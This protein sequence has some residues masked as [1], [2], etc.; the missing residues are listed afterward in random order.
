MACILILQRTSANPSQSINMPTGQLKI[1]NDFYTPQ[2]KTK[3][4][5]WICL[6]SD[7]ENS[8][9]HYPVLYMHDGQS[10]FDETISYDGSWHVNVI[11]NK[12]FKDKKTEGVIIV[13]VDNAGKNRMREYNPWEEMGGRGSL[14]ADF[15]VHTLKPYIDDNFR[16][17]PQREYT[18]IMGSS[19]GAYISTY[20]ALKNQD[21][22]SKIG[23]LSPVFWLYTEQLNSFF[24]KTQIK[25]SMKMYLSV[26]TKEGEE[27]RAA[28]YLKETK[29]VYDILRDKIS[30]KIND[31]NDIKLDVIENGTHSAAEWS[32]TF[33]SALSWLF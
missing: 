32:K 18:G 5:V 20:I 22:F 33:E 16:T 29:A 31:G 9:K 7:Y 2:L 28:Q 14:Y 23:L 17:K 1:I 24:E 25:M 30:D 8:Q 15:V 11:V 26:G 4:R 3:R 13:A 21:I 27:E 19:M 10:L 6:P 12:L